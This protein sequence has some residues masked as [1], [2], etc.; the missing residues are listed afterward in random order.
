ERRAREN[1]LTLMKSVTY[2]LPV[3]QLVFSH[4]P[5]GVSVQIFILVFQNF[6]TY[7]YGMYNLLSASKS[8]ADIT[9]GFLRLPVFHELLL[10]IICQ[11]FTVKLTKT[12]LIPLDQLSNG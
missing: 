9:R 3:S 4:N 5:I 7:S 12:I 2:G 6:L 8:M 10:R 11:V 1:M